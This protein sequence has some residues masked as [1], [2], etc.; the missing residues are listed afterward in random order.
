MLS[1]YGGATGYKNL[2]IFTFRGQVLDH[3]GSLPMTWS[4]HSK[5]HLSK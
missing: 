4:Q 5:S 2:L 1:K 3:V